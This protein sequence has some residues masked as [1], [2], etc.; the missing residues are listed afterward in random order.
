MQYIKQIAYLNTVQ[1]ASADR[2][3]SLGNYTI[4]G[5]P[6]FKLGTQSGCSFITYAGGTAAISTTDWT[7]IASSTYYYVYVEYYNT[8]VNQIQNN[9]FVYYS[10]SATAADAQTKFNTWAGNLLTEFGYTVATGGGDTVTITA[11][12]NQYLYSAL[13]ADSGATGVTSSVTTPA[14]L[15]VGYGQDIIT[16][17]GS[18]EASSGSAN[19]GIVTTGNYHMVFIP[20]NQPNPSGGFT[21]F[22]YLVCIADSA[23]GDT[24][25]ATLTSEL[26]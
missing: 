9:T 26:S 11:P 1:A 20:V 12:K 13:S 3:S 7:T 15:R 10:T 5:L 21:Q 2:V 4:N 24:L 19:D 17:Y 23:D 18:P 16:T 25:L 6:T 14:V 8:L 22:T